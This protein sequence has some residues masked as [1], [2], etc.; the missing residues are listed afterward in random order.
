MRLL[1]I[2]GTKFLGPPL[3]RSALARGHEV[4]LFNRGLFAATP[5]AGVEFVQGNRDGEIGLLA[6][7]RF[8]VA[9]DTCGFVPRVVRESVAALGESVERYIFVSSISAYAEPFGGSFAEEEP[10]AVLAD[11]ATEEVTNETYGG[12]KALCEREVVTGMP[13]RAMVVRPGLIVG[14]LD[15]SDRFTYWPTRFALGGDVLVPGGPEADV[16]FVDVRDLAQWIVEAAEKRLSGTFN[17]SGTYGAITM[18]EVIEAC[19]SAAGGGRAV[20]VSEDFVLSHGVAPWTE[21][22]LWIPQG[23]DN[24]I[25][26]SS[27][28]AVAAGLRY[29]PLV[30]TVQATLD[31]SKGLGLDRPLR[32]GLTRAREAELLAA[33]SSAAK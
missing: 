29:R 12:L 13:G 14:P 1:I 17:A 18:G 33:W 30:E 32:A 23:E 4:T 27:A 5:P 26:A 25:K 15:P 3:V 22:P 9:I 19:R 24:L 8:D 6:G 31:W 7:R 28:R 11:T 10:T 2:G 20:W 16:S 21:L